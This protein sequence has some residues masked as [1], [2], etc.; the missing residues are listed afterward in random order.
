MT[1]KMKTVSYKAEVLVGDHWSGNGLR[2]HTERAAELYGK[3]LAARWTLCSDSRTLPSDEPVTENT[4]TI[5]WA[6]GG[7]LRPDPDAPAWRVCLDDEA[8]IQHD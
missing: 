3:D 8:R 4:A 1:G 5:A 6:E 7:A 2:F